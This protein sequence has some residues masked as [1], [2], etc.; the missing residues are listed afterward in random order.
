[1]MLASGCRAKPVSRST[2]A[3]DINDREVKAS[4]DGD[5]SISSQTGGATVITFS[6]GKLII[7]KGT[8]ELDDKEVAKFPEA[9]K[10]VE[11]DY[12][13]GKLTVTADGAVV[14]TSEPG[15]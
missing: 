3:T 9:V 2:L 4:L 6:A 12:T 1:M 10:K 14:F 5:G 13:A 15:K 7:G 11:V 8:V